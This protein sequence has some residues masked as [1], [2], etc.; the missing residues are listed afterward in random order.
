MKSGGARSVPDPWG[1]LIVDVETGGSLRL[2]LERALFALRPASRDALADA[3]DDKE[4]M[5]SRASAI[6]AG[7]RVSGGEPAMQRLVA[8]RRRMPHVGFYV[9]ARSTRGLEPLLAQLAG[10]G[11][12]DAFCLESDTDWKHLEREVRRRVQA[13]PP[14]EAL[15][16]LWKEWEANAQRAVAMHLVRNGFRPM[17]AE[18]AV[19]WFAMNEKTMREHLSSA[20]IPSPGLLH[21]FGLALHGSAL[22]SWGAMERVARRLGLSSAKELQAKRRR[23]E[24]RLRSSIAHTDPAV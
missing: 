20:G 2:E 14:E 24:N 1:E 6:L 21:R 22:G 10:L 9:V 13:P 8:L 17:N 5:L 16:A 3:R 4:G 23:V 19:A 12:D 15:R 7:T 18:R 11:V